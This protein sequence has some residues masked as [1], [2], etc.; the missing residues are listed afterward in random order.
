MLG[1]VGQRAPRLQAG[2]WAWC[3]WGSW[4]VVGGSR[5]RLRVLVVGPRKGCAACE[6]QTAVL[7]WLVVVCERCVDAAAVGGAG[8]LSCWC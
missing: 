3:C 8:A 1:Q 4:C 5:G 6:G 2:L 7:L